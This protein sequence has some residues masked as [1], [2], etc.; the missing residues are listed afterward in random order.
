[1]YQRNPDGS[2]V[3]SDGVT[4]PQEIENEDWRAYLAWVSAGN[5]AQNVSI[6][7]SPAYCSAWQ[8]RKALNQLGLRQSVEDAVA[9][10]QD[11]NMKDGWE[12]SNVFG[13]DQ[14]YVVAMGQALG[15]TDAEVRAIIELASKL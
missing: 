12:F 15:K 1:M 5:V 10:S 7:Q 6:S 3:R 11:Q 13:S 4:I 14:P 2:V 8:I 9:Q